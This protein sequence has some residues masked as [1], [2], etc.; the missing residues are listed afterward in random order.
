MEEIQVARLNELETII[1]QGIRQFIDVGRCFVEI[2]ESGLYKEKYGTFN[3]YC[4]QRWGFSISYAEK[5]MRSV[6]TED[7]LKSGTIGSDDMPPQLPTNESQ[8]RAME[9]LSDDEKRAVWKES[10]ATAPGGTVTAAHIHATRQALFPKAEKE[11]S[12]QQ[13]A[14]ITCPLCNGEFFMDS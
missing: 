8:A 4:R 3:D 5:L 13:G 1:D 7:V 6:R 11:E 2:K 14:L 10:V 12:V 9:T